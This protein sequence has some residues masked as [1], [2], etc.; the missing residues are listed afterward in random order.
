MRQ[1]H[2]AGEEALRRLRRERSRTLVDGKT[3]EVSEVEL[4]VAVLRGLETTT[5]A[6]ATRTQ[7]GPDLIASHVRN[8]LL[9]LGG[10][11]LAVV[12]DQL[13]S[14]GD[15]GLPLPS[16]ASG[17]TRGLA[18]HYGTTVAAGAAR[19]VRGDKAKVE[20]GGGRWSS[21]GSWL[22]CATRPFFLARPTQ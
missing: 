2:V 19:C 22:G 9:E 21:A 14:G 1:E 13:K 7:R 5:Y 15:A 20:V 16:R 4:F 12:P 8:F 11:P 18:R 10:V 6:E 3:G 17:P